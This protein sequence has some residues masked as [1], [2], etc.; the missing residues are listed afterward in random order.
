M[1]NFDQCICFQLGRVN[2][3][4]TKRYR[5]GILKLGLTHGQFFVLCAVLEEEGLLPSQLALE[6]EMDRP[7][8]TGLLDRL[9][10]DEWVERRPDPRDRRSQCIFPSSKALEHKEAIFKLFEDINGQF[11]KV[12]TGDEWRLFQSFLSRLEHTANE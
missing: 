3:K 4:I 7:T 5:E 8:I 10:R 12:F 1:D 9:E 6:A 2:R 11:L